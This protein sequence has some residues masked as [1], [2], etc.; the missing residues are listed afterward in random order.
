MH[1]NS[2]LF[3]LHSSVG[4]DAASSSAGSKEANANAAMSLYTYM[5]RYMPCHDVQCLGYKEEDHT[6]ISN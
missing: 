2:S 4:F 3:S 1:K 5:Y 6:L